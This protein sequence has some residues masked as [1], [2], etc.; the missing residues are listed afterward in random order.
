[1]GVFECSLERKRVLG[2]R[3][4]GKGGKTAQSG[5]GGGKQ[6]NDWLGWKLQE[7][8]PLPI[9]EPKG[10][11]KETGTRLKGGGLTASVSQCEKTVK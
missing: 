6:G 7:K 4:Q 5:A 1:M 3:P 9:G 8:A 2:K 10:W 11:E